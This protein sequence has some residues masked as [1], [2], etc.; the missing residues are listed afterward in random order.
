MRSSLSTLCI[1]LSSFT[2]STISH[3][4]K[5]PAGRG[6][7]PP[8]SSEVLQEINAL[9]VLPLLVNTSQLLAGIDP[10]ALTSIPNNGINTMNS[11]P[12]PIAHTFPNLTTGTINSSTVVL[13]IDYKLARSIVPIKYEILKNSIKKVLPWFP[14]DK[15]PVLTDYSHAAS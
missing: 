13:P 6:M 15:Y 3:G 8:F 4:S 10:A 5:P 12:N 2:I 11:Q 1:F 9:S 7:E 14:H